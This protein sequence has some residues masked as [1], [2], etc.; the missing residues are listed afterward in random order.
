[1]QFTKNTR[2]FDNDGNEVIVEINYRA[3]LGDGVAEIY[4]IN[5][6]ATETAICTQPWRPNGDGSRSAWASVQEVVEWFKDRA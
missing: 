5:D 3:T 2:E 4:L 6:D 1:M